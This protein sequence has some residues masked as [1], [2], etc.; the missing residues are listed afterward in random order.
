MRCKK[1]LALALVLVLRRL[2]ALRLCFAVH[3]VQLASLALA[4]LPSCRSS[5]PASC[6]AAK[7][8]DAL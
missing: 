5:V 3:A 4:V 1:S 6:V 8:E 2:L 7:H